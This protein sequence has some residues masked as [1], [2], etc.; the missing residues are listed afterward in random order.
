MSFYFI[1]FLLEE[2]TY[3]FHFMINYDEIYYYLICFTLHDKLYFFIW[4]LNTMKHLF[5]SFFWRE[6]NLLFDQ[7]E[8]NYLLLV[9]EEEINVSSSYLFLF[10]FKNTSIFQS[11][12]NRLFDGGKIHRL[13]LVLSDFS[14]RMRE[15][16]SPSLIYFWFDGKNY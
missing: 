2:A 10:C 9:P 11:E 15:K 14:S 3:F 6:I 16:L 13:L 8:I 5:I 12:I 7:P 1:C 4:W